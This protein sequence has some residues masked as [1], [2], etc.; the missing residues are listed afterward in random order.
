[1]C[2]VVK[3]NNQQYLIHVKDITVQVIDGKAY[4]RQTSTD[5]QPQLLDIRI[6][7]FTCSEEEETR[8]MK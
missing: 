3:T 6:S 7:S 1:M 5:M 4:A 2:Y 8:I